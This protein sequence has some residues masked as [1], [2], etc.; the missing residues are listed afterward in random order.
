MLKGKAIFELTDVNTGKK[1]IYED[2]NMVTNGL[3]EFLTSYGHLGCDVLSQDKCGSSSLWTNLIGGIFL[4]DSALDEDVNNTFMPAGVKMIG[5]GSKD[6]SNSGAVTELG[7]YNAT[8]SGL[9]SDGSI[10]LV[11]DFSTQQANGTIACVCLT[12]KIGGYIGMGNSSAK[13][14]KQNYNFFEYVSEDKY[15]CYIGLEGATNGS[16]Y[17]NDLL[18]AVYNENAVYCTNRRNII[19]SEDYKSQHWSVTHKIQILKVSAA[20]SNISIK[21]SNTFKNIIQTYDIEIP[22][23]ILNYMGTNKYSV[24]PFSDIE[25][26][27]YIIFANLSYQSSDFTFEKNS[28]IWIMKIDRKMNAVAYRVTNT[29]GKNL[30]VYKKCVVFDGDYMW[31]YTNVSPYTLYGINYSNSAQIIETGISHKDKRNDIFCIERN[32]IGISGD[33]T[34]DDYYY[35]P[36]I[37]DVVSG[38]HRFTNGSAKESYG[39]IKPFIDKKGVYIFDYISSYSYYFKLLKDSRYLATINNLSEAVTKT[40]DKTMKLTYIIK[41][42]T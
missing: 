38:T 6:M 25:G 20:F 15:K 12:S 8:E 16:N 4:F 36:S 39:S 13:Y 31:L 10:K 37:Y 35:S 17:Y 33:Y 42:T 26:N 40:A 23:D 9:Q 34:S 22:S 1:E 5:N 30:Y 7:S 11:Y 21:D 24:Y 18:Y 2:T 28:S 19:Y 27:I 29:I 14:L 32:M 3:Q 41:E